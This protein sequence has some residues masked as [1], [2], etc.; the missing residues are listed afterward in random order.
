MPS[1]TATGRDPFLDN[2]KMVLVTSVV[3][4]HMLVLAAPS[5][6]QQHVYDALYLV[7]MPA[8][9]L[10]TG[11]LSR[12]FRYTRR[13]L[14]AVLTTLVVP[15]LLID[16]LLTL[17]QVV[18]FDTPRRTTP[19][20][21]PYWSMWFLVV[22]AMWRLATP[23]LRR[24]PWVV[25]AAFVLSAVAPLVDVTWFDVNR[26]LQFLPF[27][28][29]GLHA[30]KEWLTALQR[31]EARVGGVVVLLAVWWLGGRTDDWISTGWLYFSHA[32]ADLGDP[33]LTHA[34]TDRALQL[35]VSLVGAV[36]LLGVMPRSRSWITPLGAAS[37]TVYLL[38]GLVLRWLRHE[39]VLAPLDPHPVAS[40]LAALA[41]GVV[42]ALVL[43]T[44]FVVERTRWLTDPANTALASLRTRRRGDRVV[45]D[46]ATVPL[47]DAPGAAG[48]LDRR[49]DLVTAG[50]RVQL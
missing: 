6:L 29:L 33:T 36:A 34:M 13:H 11:Y 50:R 10:V 38:H 31:P 9:L 46:P 41:L 42:L 48:D 18:L 27:F 12:S 32:Y 30:R 2:A 8:F 15:Y 14:R 40:V 21:E 5:A 47:A 39:D 49:R 4:G 23:L 43:A 44:P 25:P 26:A 24:T 16:T 19:L 17:Q 28:V 45:A 22:L 7:H 1:G 3:A 37:M 20:L 35:G